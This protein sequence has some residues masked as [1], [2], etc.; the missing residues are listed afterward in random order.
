MTDSTGLSSS[1]I[2]PQVLADWDAAKRSHRWYGIR[3][4]EVTQVDIV[5][6]AEGGDVVEWKVPLHLGPH[7]GGGRRSEITAF[8]YESRFRLLKFMNSIDRRGIDANRLWFVTL[9][10]P[11]VWPNSP[12]VWKRHL[13]AFQKRLI[14]T[15][16]KLPVVWKLEPQRRGAP[17]FHLIELMPVAMCEGLAISGRRRRG[18]RIVTQW[19]G[20]QLSEFRSWLSCA[21]FEIVNSGDKK[22][23]RAGTNC[24]PLEAWGKVI[25]YA[26]KY[27]GKECAF[28]A[29]DGSDERVGRYWGVWHREGFPVLWRSVFV[30]F[31]AAAMLRRTI[32]RYYRRARFRNLR[33][34]YKSGTVFLGWDTL[35]RLLEWLVPMPD[36]VRVSYRSVD[37]LLQV[38]G[39]DGN[40]NEWFGMG[41]Q[42]R[43]ARHRAERRGTK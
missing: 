2:S 36:S 32:R 10:Y 15:W 9:T 31:S 25:A 23:L 8:T 39:Y 43:Q 38:I 4:P 20:G 41:E 19:V 35:R 37:D 13:Q 21:W 34:R 18:K 40:V 12:K 28:H 5:R 6:Y 17:H 27:L 24:E 1:H 7:L 11:A 29:P 16:G 33:G 26:S 22:H 14:R 42:D 30:H 3:P